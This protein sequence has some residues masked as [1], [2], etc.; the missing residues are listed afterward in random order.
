MPEEDAASKS[1]GLLDT[2]E[3][4]QEET[5]EEIEAEVAEVANKPEEEEVLE[6][7][8]AGDESD[9][10]PVADDEENVETDAE[11]LAASESAG[12]DPEPVDEESDVASVELLDTE[13]HALATAIAE[14]VEAFKEIDEALASDSAKESAVSNNKNGQN[15]ENDK[16]RR[17]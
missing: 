1:A 12:D 10:E 9:A 6:A 8:D 7:E 13:D 3:D 17:E 14:T 4:I 2:D 15:G 5:A 11:T 16:K